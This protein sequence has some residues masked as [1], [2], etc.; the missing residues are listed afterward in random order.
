MREVLVVYPRRKVDMRSKKAV[1]EKLDLK[2]KAENF[3]YHHKSYLF[4][5]CNN[6]WQTV[7]SNKCADVSV[8]RWDVVGQ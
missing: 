3:L 6:D 5:Q 1:H 7:L 8:M 4:Y 2:R